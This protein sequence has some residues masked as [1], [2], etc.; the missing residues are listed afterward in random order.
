MHAELELKTLMSSH[1]VSL[2]T[3]ESHQ[4]M[5]SNRRRH[6]S[7]KYTIAIKNLIIVLSALLCLSIGAVEVPWIKCSFPNW[8]RLLLRSSWTCQAHVLPAHKLRSL[9]RLIY[10]RVPPARLPLQISSASAREHT[11]KVMLE[12]SGWGKE[13]TVTSAASTALILSDRRSPW[14]RSR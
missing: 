8:L 3:I 6:A 12:A 14:N 4:R 13:R 1:A 2:V 7:V 5:G 11:S 10:L 9:H